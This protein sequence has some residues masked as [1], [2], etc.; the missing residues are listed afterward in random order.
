MD[1]IYY[2]IVAAAILYV[3]IVLLTG[4]F[5]V[6]YFLLRKG[7]RELNPETHPPVNCAECGTITSGFVYRERED[8]V[9]ERNAFCPDCY[10][11][12]GV[13]AASAA[14]G[15]RVLNCPECGTETSGTVYKYYGGKTLREFCPDCIGKTGRFSAEREPKFFFCRI[16]IL[17]DKSRSDAAMYDRMYWHDIFYEETEELIVPAVSANYSIAPAVS[18]PRGPRVF[19]CPECGTETSG[20]IYKHSSGTE[21]IYLVGHGGIN[22]W[23]AMCPD[24]YETK[25]NREIERELRNSYNIR[26]IFLSSREE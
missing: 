2:F 11:R 16:I 5:L 20:T 4:P 19:N 7:K 26:D 17:I 23:N 12:T 1:I 25:K 8:G 18:A 22:Q 10:G 6:F 3:L 14:W 24:C 9:E 13:P 15:P 21:F